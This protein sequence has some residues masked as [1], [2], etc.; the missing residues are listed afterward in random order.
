M[1]AFVSNGGTQLV[2]VYGTGNVAVAF[3]VSYNTTVSSG[4]TQII[5]SGCTAISTI[6]DPGGHQVVNAHSL[7]SATV[8]IGL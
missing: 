1:D 4:G 8:Y 3:G 6:L 2:D 5:D 7:I